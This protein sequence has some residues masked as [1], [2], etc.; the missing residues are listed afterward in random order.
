LEKELV[1]KAKVIFIAN[2]QWNMLELLMN[3]PKDF[4]DK[5]NDYIS[6]L[7]YSASFNP[8]Y[9]TDFGAITEPV[10][11]NNQVF[12]PYFFKKLT[13]VKIKAS[14]SPVLYT[15]FLLTPSNEVKQRFLGEVA[16]KK[17]GEKYDEDVI[18]SYYIPVF[19]EATDVK[20]LTNDLQNVLEQGLYQGK[21]YSFQLGTITVTKDFDFAFVYLELNSLMKVV[22]EVQDSAEFEVVGA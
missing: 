16:K 8:G 17:N 4:L 10:T 18:G 19:P 13:G 15:F 9:N 20:E 11:L 12:K 1:G 3:N 21:D 7:L 5:T 6:Q 2:S 14:N 22:N